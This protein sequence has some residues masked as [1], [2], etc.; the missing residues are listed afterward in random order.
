M[1]RRAAR[2]LKRTCLH[3]LAWLLAGCASNSYLDAPPS[4]GFLYSKRVQIAYA[5]ELR[6][7][8]EVGVI[9][10]DGIVAIE[11][12]DDVPVR[13]IRSFQKRAWYSNGRYQL[14]LLP[15][16]HRLTLS[17]SFYFGTTH[18]TRFAYSTSDLSKVVHLEKGQVLHLSLINMGRQWDVRAS[19]GSA[20]LA[21]IRADFAALTAGERN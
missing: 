12:V 10:T 2:A 4:L 19:D 3:G 9:T 21:E 1:P 8:D 15:G 14:H 6:G 18:F 13:E 7:L 11:S 20:A 16:S 17:F 5:G